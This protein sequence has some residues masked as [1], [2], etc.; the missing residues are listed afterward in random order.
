MSATSFNILGRN[1][2][3]FVADISR[4]DLGEKQ[5][6]D[7]NQLLTNPYISLYSLD[8]TNRQA[9]FVELPA[10]IKL[11][12]AP[13]Y[14][15]MQ[16]NHAQKVIT[17]DFKDFYALAENISFDASHLII[18]HTIG[19]A[20][21]TLLSKAFNQ[22]DNILSYSE[23]DVF[24]NITHAKH[25]TVDEQGLLIR[26]C[27]PYIFRPEVLGDK[28]YYVT[29]FRGMCT[30]LLD[31]FCDVFPTSKH[32]FLYRNAVDWVTSMYRIRLQNEHGRPIDKVNRQETAE[33]L[34]NFLGIYPDEILNYIPNDS[35]EFTFFQ[36]SSIIWSYLMDK[37]QS[38]I[39]SNPVSILSINFEELVTHPAETI[40]K[41]FIHCGLS[42]DAVSS[43]LKAFDSDS[44]A[45]TRFAQGD[46]V[47]LTESQHE[48]IINMLSHQSIQSAYYS[49]SNTLNYDDAVYRNQYVSQWHS[50]F[51]KELYQGQW[52][53]INKGLSGAYLY[54]GVHDSKACFLKVTT[55]DHRMPVKAEYERIKWFIKLSQVPVV[56]FAEYLEDNDYQYLVTEQVDGVDLFE[57]EAEPET[58]IRTYAQAIRMFHDLPIVSCPFKTSIDDQIEFARKTLENGEVNVSLLDTEFQGR[59]LHGLFD[60]MVAH[61]PATP[62]NVVIHGDPY[63]D[64]LIVNPET[65]KIRAWIDLGNVAVGDRYTDLAMIY[66]DIFHAFGE[67]GWQ[68]FLKEYGLEKID[69]SRM[70]FYQLFNEFM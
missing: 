18:I 49:V 62:D 54:Q 37:A 45:G 9:V 56:Q 63:D 70:R 23:P 22:L 21:S 39:K 33:G 24:T 14:Y 26:A 7:I 46:K 32:L 52:K 59:D 3:S 11:E 42:E 47:T 12:D 29:K 8:F 16:F 43:A 51:P 67:E 10:D 31:V 30:R 17:L 66:D 58:I 68:L 65:G 41:I 69:K 34:A 35:D 48:Q 53:L 28:E 64:N 2:E 15:E 5:A 44:Q 40:T 13:F 4:F 6:F 36:G 61:R 55:H 27:M 20:G 38:S 19:R 1:E 60:E 50:K 25:L 57:C